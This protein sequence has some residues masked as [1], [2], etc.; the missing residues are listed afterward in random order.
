LHEIGHNWE[1]SDFPKW[2][3]FIKLSGWTEPAP[4]PVR[5][6][7]FKS[8]DSEASATGSQPNVRVTVN[9]SN[10]FGGGVLPY[11][12]RPNGHGGF[13]AQGGSTATLEFRP[14]GR[15]T[16]TESN[17]QVTQVTYYN[18]RGELT[19]SWQYNTNSAFASK[20]A[21]TNSG[22]DF[23]ESFAAYFLRDAA[24]NWTPTPEE[25]SAAVPTAKNNLIRDWIATLV[26]P[27]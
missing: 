19:G 21:R 22:E 20:Y 2:D 14:G 6:L 18:S 25:G 10:P 12:F 8:T 9:G 13:T 3:D 11:S 5:S 23:S 27:S 17:G 15:W 26:T 24:G 1:P 16:L 4:E 7:S